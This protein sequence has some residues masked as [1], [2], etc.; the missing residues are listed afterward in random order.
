MDDFNRVDRVC[1][2]LQA[3]AVRVSGGGAGRGGPGADGCGG[4]G[5]EP[6]YGERYSQ[7]ERLH[8]RTLGSAAR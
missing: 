5:R 6:D 8:A 7:V 4:D 1:I 2:L 3:A